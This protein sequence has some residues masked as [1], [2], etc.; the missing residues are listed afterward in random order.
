MTNL[1]EVDTQLEVLQKK[2]ADVIREGENLKRLLANLYKQ[3]DDKSANSAR[4]KEITAQIEPVQR[5]LE[6]LT[7]EVFHAHHRHKHGN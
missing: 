4:Q 2:R 5:E 6:H 3:L 1:Q 7:G